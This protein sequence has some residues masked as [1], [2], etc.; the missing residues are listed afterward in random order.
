[1]CGIAA[2]ARLGGGLSPAL[3]EA[4]VSRMTDTIVH[5]GPDDHGTF[6]DPE[7]GVALGHRRLSIIDLSAAGHQPM[8]TPD[9]RL[10]LSYNGELYNHGALRTQLSSAGI[11]FTGRSDTEVL[12]HALATWG[13]QGALRR[14]D[15]MFAF[16]ALDRLGRQLWLARDAFGEKP[17]YVGR[18]AD[19]V[20]IASEVQALRAVAG[21]ALRVDRDALAT[22]IRYGCMNDGGSIYAGVTQ[23]PAGGWMK[24]DLATGTTTSG[25]WFDAAAEMAS[26]VADP[27]PDDPV[28]IADEV[29]V[30]VRSAVRSRLDADVPLGAFLSGGIDSSLVVA[31]LAEEVRHPVQTFT[32]GFDDGPYDESAAAAAVARHLGT[33]HHELI[34]RPDDAL[35]ALPLLA[36]RYGEPFAD[37]SAIPTGMVAQLAREHVTVALSGDGGDELFGGYDRYRRTLRLWPKLA[38]VPAPLRRFGGSAID[39]VPDRIVHGLT[40]GAR[41]TFGPRA[42]ALTAERVDRLAGSLRARS[43]DELYRSIRSDALDP[44]RIVIGGHDRPTPY[45]DMAR[46]GSLDALE[47]MMLADTLAYLPA[48]ILTKV[49]RA[50]MAVSLETRVPLLDPALARVA[51]RIPPHRRATADHGKLVLRGLLRRHL[52]DELVDRPKQGFAVPVLSWVRGPLRPWAEDLL[53]PDRLRAEGFFDVD[54]VRGLWSSHLGR[55]DSSGYWLW[56]VLSFQAWLRAF[57][58]TG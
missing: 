12:L 35:R 56:N 52:P 47:R 58:T 45:D 46:H 43:V 42:A 55:Q 17:L 41:G 50:G 22:F 36:E 30:A 32:I 19:D 25:R 31:M 34:V 21:A 54:L 53:A 10:I 13:L 16:A 4:R 26:A 6:V 48:D 40:R 5:R 11:N 24:I 27:F 38:R 15:G 9:G 3:L 18:W 44:S 8:A 28:L 49:D 23:L 33:D 7:L 39:A 14:A 37:A 20:G 51:W 29:A 1:M 57:P 2:Y